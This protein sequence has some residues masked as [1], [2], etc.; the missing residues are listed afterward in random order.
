MNVCRLWIVAG[1]NGAGK[2]TLVARHNVNQYSISNPDIIAAKLSPQRPE[3]ATLTAGRLALRQRRDFFARS[4]SFILE[5]TFS[6]KN[7]TRDIQEAKKRGYK[8]SLVFVALKSPVQSAARVASRTVDGGHH[9]DLSDIM[10][11]FGR[12]Y[13]N[14]NE[15]L[16]LA[17]RVYICDNS[18][19][20]S[21]PFV[22]KFEEG[23]LVKKA[24]TVPIWLANKVPN[25][26]K[27]PE[28]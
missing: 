6:G 4:E 9:V 3:G 21:Y 16:D 13:A 7:A 17:D 2:S 25:L 12:C 28:Q 22:T 18:T 14:L 19:N 24:P 20:R 15:S 10:R 23:Q 27:S 1:P 8:V 5:T 11:R 26:T